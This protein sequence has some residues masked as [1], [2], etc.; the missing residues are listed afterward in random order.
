MIPLYILGLLLRLGP[1]RGY[2]IKKLMEEQLEDFTQ[3]KLPMVYYHL[4]KME[5]AGL[6]TAHRDKQ[7]ACPEKTVIR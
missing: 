2:Q 1:Q 4:E 5:I 3:I 7:G 6:V